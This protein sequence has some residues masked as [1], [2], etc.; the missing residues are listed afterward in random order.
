MKA[1]YRAYAAYQD[2]FAMFVTLLTLGAL[3]SRQGR[4]EAIEASVGTGSSSDGEGTQH[5]FVNERDGDF[6]IPP[7]IPGASKAE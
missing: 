2:R 6:G 1:K 7:A 3:L 4:Q 5:V